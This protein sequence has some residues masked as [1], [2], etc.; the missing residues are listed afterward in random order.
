MFVVLKDVGTTFY[1]VIS[2]EKIRCAIVVL[3][4]VNR[5]VHDASFWFIIAI[6]GYSIF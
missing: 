4:A 5:S 6:E 3:T 1:G 2:I